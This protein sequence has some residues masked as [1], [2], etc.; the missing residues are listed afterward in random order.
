MYLSIYL[1]PKWITV[2][3][4]SFQALYTSNRNILTYM[5]IPQKR[6]FLPSTPPHLSDF[7]FL[8]KITFYSNINHLQLPHEISVQLS[9]V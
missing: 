7:N 5:S 2:I 9:G 8:S 4:A 3:H 6:I 1:S